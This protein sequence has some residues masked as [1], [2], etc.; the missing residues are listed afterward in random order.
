[1]LQKGKLFIAKR[2]DKIK[3]LYGTYGINSKNMN[4]NSIPNKK[5]FNDKLSDME[6]SNFENN[7]NSNGDLYMVNL[8]KIKT[9]I[10]KY[11]KSNKVFH[12]KQP[13]LKKIKKI[14]I[15]RIL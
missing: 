14:L 8:H 7:N 9:K 2:G 11:P 6:K 10:P 12:Q 15:L 5:S 1:M 3:T 4:N 13:K